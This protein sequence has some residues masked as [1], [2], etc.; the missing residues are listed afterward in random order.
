MIY[1]YPVQWPIG[2][3]RNDSHELA[4]FKVNYDIALRGL[5]YE[6]EQLGADSAYI[7][8]DQELRVNGVPRRDRVP[9]SPAVAVYF[10]RNGKQLCIP[11]DKFQT[12]RDNI[13]A[14]GLTLESIRRMERYGTSQTVEATLSGFAALPA[15]ASPNAGPRAWHEVLQVSSDADPSVIRAA[16]R[17]LAAKY[18]PDN[19][20]TGN[21]EKFLEV[22][23]AF[24]E[25]GI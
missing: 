9:D 13:R 7:S 11:C 19:A 21:Q 15:E 1:H 24:K 25:S 6:L 22:S 14:I 23:R 3:P 2:W 8:T 12:V 10:V 5:A 20:S 18:H 16:Y 17:N 4:R